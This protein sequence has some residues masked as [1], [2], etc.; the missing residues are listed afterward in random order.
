MKTAKSRRSRRDATILPETIM[1]GRALAR[2]ARGLG[3]VCE[4]ILI[5]LTTRV[6]PREGR[7]ERAVP[8]GRPVVILSPVSR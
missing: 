6:W 4:K 2:C 5:M 7:G 1:A 8:A 3:I